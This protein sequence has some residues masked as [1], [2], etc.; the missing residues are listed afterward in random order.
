MVVGV[1]YHHFRTPPVYYLVFQIPAAV[2]FGLGLV[3]EVQLPLTNVRCPRKPIG[4]YYI[5]TQHLRIG[6]GPLGR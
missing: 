5:F 1:G 4:I 3:F 2:W 6:S